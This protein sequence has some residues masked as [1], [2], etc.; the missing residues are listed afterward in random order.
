[1]IMYSFVQYKNVFTWPE[2]SESKVML[3]NILPRV[4]KFDIQWKS[5]QHLFHYI[6]LFFFFKKKKEHEKMWKNEKS[7]Y[8]FLDVFV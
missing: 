4:N 7:F 6:L 5:M 3:N 8:I 2:A 1:M